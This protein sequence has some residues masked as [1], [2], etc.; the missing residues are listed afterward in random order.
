MNQ[1]RSTGLVT[2]AAALG[3][4]TC[5]SPAWA[6]FPGMNGKIAFEANRD[7]SREVYVT[8]ADG[9]GQ[10]NLTNNLDEDDDPRWSPDGTKIVFARET[11]SSDEDIYVMDAD[12][13]QVVQ[14]T[15]HPAQDE[16]PS[17]SPDGTKIVFQS[18]RDGNGEVYVMNADGSG[19]TNLTN[20]PFGEDEPHF[21][22][23]GSRIAFDTDRDSN[24]EIYVMNADGSSQTN[25]SNHPAND[26]DLNW[27]PDGARI[28]FN[29]DRDGND[30]VYVMDA[31]G[32]NQTRLTSDPAEDDQPAFSPDG[33]KIAFES[34]RDGDAEIFVMNADGSNPIQR[35]SNTTEDEEPD[36]QPTTEPGPGCT[37]AP[38]L[39]SINC[40]LDE[41]LAL[42]N[43]S[44]E[45]GDLQAAI[46]A[47]IT[48][49][50]A[51]KDKAEIRCQDGKLGGAKRLVGKAGRKVK[52]TA[53]KIDSRRGQ[54]TIPES[55]RTTLLATLAAI[56]ADLTT[57]KPTLTCSPI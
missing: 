19:Q 12:G 39:E 35:T 33:T 17:W 41:L 47:G 49:A 13:S 18:D 16:D 7:A 36:W 11:A 45:L 9:S 5:T 57:L 51:K 31:N 53:K 25:V 6:A 27:S 50:T 24:N 22:P 10:T 42:V 23:D 26:V 55:L 32:A 46:A 8:N 2:L 37:V 30:E 52:S 38:T 43:A 21:S 44:T 1:R 40:R 3:W 54:D 15:T 20:S 56:R 34:S 14:L 28:A 4:A 29:T 48:Q